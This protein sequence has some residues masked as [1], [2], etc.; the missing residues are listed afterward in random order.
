MLVADTNIIMRLVVDDDPMQSYRVKALLHKL[1]QSR[2]QLALTQLVVAEC[3]WVLESMKRPRQVIAE[4][5]EAVLS[6]DVFKVEEKERMERALQ[7]YA[8][9][10]VDFVDAY[11]AGASEESGH[12]GV[13][14]FDKD[15]GKLGVHWVRP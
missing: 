12:T 4:L 2:G 9:H 5:L 3:V 6:M 8:E 15:I 10:R 1:E 11:L 7:R 13:L 14:S